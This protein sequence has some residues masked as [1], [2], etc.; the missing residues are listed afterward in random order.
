MFKKSVIWK[1]ILPIP[2]VVLLGVAA[3]WV[4]LPP[5][6]AQNARD[7]AVRSGQQTAN[8]FK[9]IRGYYT[10][11]VIQKAVRSGALKPS[12]NH[13]T[14][15]DSIPLPATLIHDLSALLAQ[16]ETSVNLY[17]RF[18]FP[19]RGDRRLDPFQAAAWDFL[20]ANPG[21][22]F[23][24][25]EER[26][27]REVVRVAVADTMV[28]QGCVDCHNSHP[29]SPKTDWRLGQ[30]RGVL[31]VASFIDTELI[32]GQAASNKILIAI[33]VGGVALTGAAVVAAK[34]V[35]G[36]LI[37]MTKTMDKLAAGEHDIDVPYVDRADE[38]GQMAGSVEVF[39][40]NALR[41][42]DLESEQSREHESK[43]QRTQV[44]TQLMTDFDA[45]V[46]DVLGKQVSATE[47]LKM[48][49]NMMTESAEQVTHKSST[50]AAA[51]Q[52]ASAN[53]ETVA[54][55]AEELT[56]SIGEIGRQVGQSVEIAQ[57]AVA[58]AEKTNADVQSLAAVAQKIS[59][60][61]ELISDIAS[62]TNLLALNATIEAARAGEAGKGFAVVASEVKSLANQTAK[63]TEEITAQIE[64]MQGATSTT[65]EAIKL[66][67]G[68]IN[69]IAEIASGIATAVEHQGS[70]TTEIARN[71]QEAAKGTQDVTHNISDVNEAA[72]D[73]GK[74]A[75]DVL[76]AAGDLADQSRTLQ[77][78]VG[79]FLDKVRTA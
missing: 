55:A 69:E 7:G 15:P 51:S 9:T 60:V 25:Q 43:E 45:R 14:E 56:S 35:S 39:K 44:V 58:D 3:A 77:D 54:A 23:V 24:R 38:I 41:R 10:K 66:V 67:G 18:P 61:V 22:V 75:G 17:S 26:G 50:I 12:F 47:A 30:V 37:G 52:E 4:L 71:I 8:Q 20:V 74:S 49:A 16:E 31:E 5:L 72:G 46:T 76:Q 65:V 1:L 36:P 13:A 34:G 11:N 27:G 21:E 73:A 2:V 79:S 6:M 53:V 59:E 42:I 68:R 33:L 32:A 78:E 57:G 48:T 40:R 63:A 70:A 64:E 29:A 19:I 62:Q 28:A